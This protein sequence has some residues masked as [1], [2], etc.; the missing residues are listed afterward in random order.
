[1]QLRKTALCLH[2][3]IH[4]LSEIRAHE[5]RIRS[6]QTVLSSDHI[7]AVISCQV[8]LGIIILWRV[9]SLI[10]GDSVNSGRC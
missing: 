1:M 5:H 6:V 9:D 2:A 8:C 7:T 4:S 3:H 10:G